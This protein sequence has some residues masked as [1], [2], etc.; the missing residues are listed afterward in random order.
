LIRQE[1]EK[2]NTHTTEGSASS[3][4]T[5]SL[6][7]ADVLTQ[8]NALIEEEKA[9]IAKTVL[10]SFLDDQ[11]HPAVWAKLARVY[12]VLGE[13]LAARAILRNV[14]LKLTQ[15]HVMDIIAAKVPYTKVIT[16]DNLK[17][18][19]VNIP[20]CG[21]SSIKDAVLV[22]NQRELRGETSH[23]HVREFEKIVPFSALDGEYG[24]Y[25]K[26]AVIRPPRDRLRSY[27]SKN[28]LE[29]RSLVKEAHGRS[30]FYGLET[31]PSYN[32]VLKMFTEYRNVF[33]DF[34]HHTDTT[35]GYL[36]L[37]K[38]RYTHIF[39]ISETK[40][41]IALLEGLVG[42]EMP[43]IHNMRSKGGN[44][45][46]GDADLDTEAELIESTYRKEIKVY[47]T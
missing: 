42:T 29:A 3:V 34:R 32:M 17:V 5:P 37:E 9:E 18:V 16:L 36:G 6:T 14:V 2:I 11:D 8:A 28:I 22:A 20:K 21:S 43:A 46:F 19:Y 47:F 15:P 10:T 23:Y 26:F 41:A 27:Y 30:N 13:P 1:E 25:T 12:R 7:A 45:G 39:G 40:K 44:E 24:G 33:D 35:I 38:S 4:T 31:V